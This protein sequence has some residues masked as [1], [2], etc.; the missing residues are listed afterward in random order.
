MEFLEHIF[1]NREASIII[2]GGVFIAWAFFHKSFRESIK[3][4]LKSFLVVKIVIP[5]ILMFVYAVGMV[6][7]F[8]KV[9]LWDISMLKDTVYWSIGVAF[10]MTMNIVEVNRDKDFFKKVVFDNLKMV[11]IL[12][13]IVS[14]YVFDFW[15]EFV[16]VP[17][18]AFTITSK[19]IAERELR[20]NQVVK[21]FEKITGIYVLA[22][23]FFTAYSILIDFSNFATVE[24]IKS[25]LLPPVF[26]I[27]FLPFVYVVALY[28][29]YE[30]I[31]IRL[32]AYNQDSELINFAR[33]KIFLTFHINLRQLNKWSREIGAM[34]VSS[35][36]DVSQF[37]QQY[38]SKRF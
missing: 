25:L 38:K 8:R 11:I 35:T 2:W 20:Y 31:F 28:M 9:G 22:V 6:F 36:D 29:Q 32:G 13:F 1:N 4:L 27:L 34:R 16:L 26:T 3:A 21:L 12:E 33:R 17:I 7:I 14:L 10:A 23:F 30:L 5:T 18:I 15:V 37:L 19:S 24:N